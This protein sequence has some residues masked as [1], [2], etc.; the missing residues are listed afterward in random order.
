LR[1]VLGAI[2]FGG[3]DEDVLECILDRDGA[4][5]VNTLTKSI[6]FSKLES[7]LS[8]IRK[9][10]ITGVGHLFSIAMDQEQGNTFVI[11]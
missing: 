1:V 7:K 11:H 9:Q 6:G 2:L 4:R 8:N 3:V 10:H 5:V